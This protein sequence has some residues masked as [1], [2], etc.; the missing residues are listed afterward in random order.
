MIAT[1]GY[2]FFL[3][4]FL[5]GWLALAMTLKCSEGRLRF[6]A[7]I[8]PNLLKKSGSFFDRVTFGLE[9]FSLTSGLGVKTFILFMEK[10][11]PQRGCG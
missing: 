11:I 6:S 4:L 10:I 9:G 2:C 1:F 8:L 7:L 5:R 3:S